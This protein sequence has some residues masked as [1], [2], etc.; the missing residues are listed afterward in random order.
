MVK[1]KTI[2]RKNEKNSFRRRLGFLLSLSLS[3]S[4]KRGLIFEKYFITKSTKKN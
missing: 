2:K 4:R 3:L 1:K